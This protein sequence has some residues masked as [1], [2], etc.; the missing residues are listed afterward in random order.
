MAPLTDL[1]SIAQE[2]FA[3][4]E[5]PAFAPHLMPENGAWKLRNMLLDDDGSAYKR[6]GSTMKSAAALGAAGLR[7]LWDG[8]LAGGHRTLFASPAAFGVLD[9]DD[10]SVIDLGGGGMSD[11][12]RPVVFDQILFV[13]DRMYGGSRIAAAYAVGSVSVVA[14]SPTVVGV[15]TAWLAHVDIGMLIQIDGGQIYA[16]AGVTDDTH[17]ELAK[18]FAGATAAGRPYSAQAV[19]PIASPY[20]SS[21]VYAT[22]GGRLIACEG[23]RAYESSIGDAASW[24]NVDGL[25]TYHEVPGAEIHGA[26]ALGD[27]VVLFTSEGVWSISNVAF[28]LVDDFGD[29]QQQLEPLSREVIL[30]SNEGIAAWQNALV[31]PAVDGVWLVG[32]GQ[33]PQLL[34]RSIT[35][36]YVQYVGAGYKTGLAAVM[37]SHYL[38]P[39]LDASNNVIDLLVCRLDRPVRTGRGVIWPWTHFRGSGANMVALATRIGG[40]PREPALLGAE[41]GAGSRIIQFAEFVADGPDVDHDGSAFE[42]DV[43]SRD[44]QTGQLNRNLVKWLEARYELVGGATIEGSYGTDDRSPATNWGSFLWDD[45]GWTDAEDVGFAPLVGADAPPSGGDAPYRWTANKRVRFFRVRLRSSAPAQRAVLRSLQMWVR[46]SG[47]P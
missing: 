41:R 32:L 39:I 43:I 18:P 46:P 22:A 37:K 36:R 17:L 31:V 1:V 2:D 35:P 7:F 9:V 16:V 3:A 10:A 27:Y 24:L 38:L 28:D 5:V 14:G 23:A 47:R 44:F 25:E 11:P 19:M 13:G 26:D 6:G 40:A 4:G 45:A 8:F 29:Q 30:W 33:A 20:R 34:S 42:W 15:G 21:Q 12:L